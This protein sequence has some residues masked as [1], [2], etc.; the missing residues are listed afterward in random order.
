MRDLSSSLGLSSQRSTFDYGPHVQT[1][2]SGEVHVA[3]DATP[4]P[5]ARRPQLTEELR[6]E[7][8]EVFELFD[9]TNSG[10]V[11]RR[12]LKVMMRLLGYEPRKDQLSRIL[13]QCGISQRSTRIE[14]DEFHSLMLHIMNE[15]DIQEEMARAFFLFDVDKTGKISFQNLKQVAETLGEKMTDAE[16]EEMIREADLNKDGFVD[17]TEFVR[18]MKKTDLWSTL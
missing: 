10:F 13:T 11:D 14:Y 7:I 3:L 12:Q 16:L 8:R 5:L 1:G 6:Q 2:N 4:R 15:K 17:E 9:S 18:I